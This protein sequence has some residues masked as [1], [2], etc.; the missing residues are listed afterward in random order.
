MTFE[1]IQDFLRQQFSDVGD[2][3]VISHHDELAGGWYLC[4]TAHDNPWD[5]RTDGVPVKTTPLSGQETKYRTLWRGECPHADDILIIWQST[6]QS[7]GEFVDLPNDYE[8]SV[9]VGP[10]ENAA[11]G[12]AQIA[13]D[14]DATLR[15]EIAYDLSDIKHRLHALSK[16]MTATERADI[17]T[18]LGELT[19]S[20]L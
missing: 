14:H 7:F 15:S 6:R 2:E 17:L 9:W 11:E 19:R 10:K 20:T 5:M 3:H 16:S 18:R 1:E 8:I 13:S 12:R 4:I